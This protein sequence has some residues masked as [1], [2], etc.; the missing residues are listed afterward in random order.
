[1][2]CTVCYD[3]TGDIKVKCGH[4]FCGPCAKEWFTRNQEPTCPMCRGPFVFK[5]VKA[6]ID[7]KNTRDLLFEEG[8]NAIVYNDRRSFIWYDIGDGKM[9]GH[10]VSK[11][12]KLAA[13]QKAYNE[14]TE[15]YGCMD[16]F[17]DEE[18]IQDFALYTPFDIFETSTIREHRDPVDKWVTKYPKRVKNVK[19]QKR[20]N[21]VYR[22]SFSKR[23]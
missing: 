21:G 8:F 23:V 10:R 15:Y 2:E 20:K 11:I 19:H 13:Y 22:A 9:C 7:E 16:E 5:G 17:M 12:A 3:R 4:V 1:M 18:G 14:C 6:W